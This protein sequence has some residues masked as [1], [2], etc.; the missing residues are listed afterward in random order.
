[1]IHEGEEQENLSEYLPYISDND[2]FYILDG[3]IFIPYEIYNKINEGKIIDNDIYN[4]LVQAINHLYR[5]EKIIKECD[6]LYNL[7]KEGV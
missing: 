2:K 5:A 4:Y 1:M 6:G 3:M 7:I